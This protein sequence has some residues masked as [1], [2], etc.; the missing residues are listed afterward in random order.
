VVTFFAGSL[1]MLLGAWLIARGY[2]P[3]RRYAVTLRQ[4]HALSSR[5]ILPAAIEGRVVSR[6]GLL[7]LTLGIAIVLLDGAATLVSFTSV[8]VVI[9]IES[10]FLILH[11]RYAKQVMKVMA[12]GVAPEP[13]T[14]SF[15]SGRGLAV[16]I[17]ATDDTASHLSH[18][19]ALVGAERE[20]ETN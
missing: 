17:G 18:H 11:Q 14:R 7:M 6:T 3:M 19:V 13:I 8:G 20:S 9:L 4:C 16:P 10:L 2:V 12:D 15:G 1:V 5:S